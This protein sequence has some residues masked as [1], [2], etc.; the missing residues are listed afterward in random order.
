MP[1]FDPLRIADVSADVALLAGGGAAILLQIAHPA[2]G[3]AV[4]EHSD[5]ARRPLDR[6]NGTLTYLYVTVY[7]TPAEAAEVARR[8]GAA[9]RPVRADSYDARDPQLQLWVAATLYDTATRVRELVFGPLREVDAET[10]LADYAVIATALGVPR[11][12]WPADR[13]AFAAYWNESVASLRVTDAS[14]RV[15]QQLL[16]PTG[17]PW[18]LRASMPLVRVLTA[19]LLSR[20]LR[21]AYALPHHQKRFD[22]IMRVTRAVYPHLP[23]WVRF[24]AQRRYL[25]SFRRSLADAT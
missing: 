7:G 12:L 8:V 4:A 21:E 19:G 1:A 23:R 9:H 11:A 3:Q 25:A 6:L 17:G 15:A 16:H 13:A 2:V 24:A 10:L 5:F 22:R 14:Q 18:W 20:E